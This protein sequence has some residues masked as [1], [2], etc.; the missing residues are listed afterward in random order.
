MLDEHFE[1]ARRTTDSR[2][3]RGTSKPTALLAIA[4]A[5]ARVPGRDVLRDAQIVDV[6][7]LRI[8]RRFDA[9]ERLDALGI[10]LGVVG[11]EAGLVEADEVSGVETSTSQP[12][13]SPSPILSKV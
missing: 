12:E 9:G 7:R 13:T 6:F 1:V 11:E 5:E 10:E 3:R 8:E 2:S 4:E